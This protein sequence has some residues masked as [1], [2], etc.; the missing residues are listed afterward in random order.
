MS[1]MHSSVITSIKNQI[2]IWALD[3][4]RLE[5]S[6]GV[7]FDNFESEVQFRQVRDYAKQHGFILWENVE[8]MALFTTED[9]QDKIQTFF[10]DNC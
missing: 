9:S 10:L 6:S 2:S 7:L 4:N 3:Q 8:K 1:T 5:Y